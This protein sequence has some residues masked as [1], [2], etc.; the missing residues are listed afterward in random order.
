MCAVGGMELGEDVLVAD[1]GYQSRVADAGLVENGEYLAQP[2]VD[3]ADGIEI[4]VHW[5]MLDSAVV[6]GILNVCIILW[7][8]P[9]MMRGTGD[10]RDEKASIIVDCV[11]DHVP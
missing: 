2:V 7:G 11:Q 1:N 10:L 9:R 4:V 6:S 5:A 8:A 3:V